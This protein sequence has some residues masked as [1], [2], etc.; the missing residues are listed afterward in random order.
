M[1]CKIVFKKSR[2]TMQNEIKTKY[3]FKIHFNV[4]NTKNN[5]NKTHLKSNVLIYSTT[6]TSGIAR[7]FAWYFIGKRQQYCHFLL[8]SSSSILVFLWRI[9]KVYYGRTT[10]KKIFITKL[11]YLYSIT[12]W[13]ANIYGSTSFI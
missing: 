12:S 11:N 7:F 3:K 8:G 9:C 10:K 6:S 2:S 5:W 13:Y 4:I 1:T